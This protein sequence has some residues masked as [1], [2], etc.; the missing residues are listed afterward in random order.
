MR[1]LRVGFFLLVLGCLLVALP[2]GAQDAPQFNEKLLPKI[3]PALLRELEQAPD[4]IATFLVYLGGQADLSP[5]AGLA[6]RAEQGRWVY[7]AL[8]AHAEQS[9]A[10]IRAYLDAAQ[11]EGRV[12]AYTPFWIVNGLSVTADAA[13]L[14]D[15]AARDEVD[16][17]MPRTHLHPRP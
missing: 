13:V 7:D 17:I 3:D 2:V 8:R 4:G 5:A 14:W 15:L 12:R 16:H 1:K 9:Q 10:G 11:R 6:S